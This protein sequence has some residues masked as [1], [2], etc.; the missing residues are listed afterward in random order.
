M[1]VYYEEV[2]FR[3]RNWKKIK[4]L[5]VKVISKEG[6]F[7]GD[8]NFIFAG[9]EFI[10]SINREFLNH[11]RYTDVISF[12]YGEENDIYGEVYISV[13]QV[14]INAMNYKVS[15]SEEMLRVMIHG[16]LH[17]CGYNDYTKEEMAIMRRREDFWLKYYAGENGI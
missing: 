12:N 7:S 14:K 9:N 2:A 15:Y 13:E 3:L 4:E 1:K 11:N 10:K 8:L 5:I 17:I 6:K 16:V